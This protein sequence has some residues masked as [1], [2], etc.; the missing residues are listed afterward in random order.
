MQYAGDTAYYPARNFGYTPDTLGQFIDDLS[1]RENLT[2][3]K[4]HY[5]YR[6]EKGNF[7]STTYIHLSAETV[8]SLLL[9]DTTLQNVYDQQKMYPQLVGIAIDVPILGHRNISLAVTE[10]GY[11]TTN[12]LDTGKAFFIGEE[13]AAA[14]LAYVL[15]NCALDSDHVF[16]NTPADPDGSPEG[17]EETVTATTRTRPAY[18]PE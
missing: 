6:D 10:D 11:L 3:G 1:L 9:D 13:K 18:K 14:F 8:W 7:H 15:E 17:T 12:I 5:D 4:V 2:V 16:V